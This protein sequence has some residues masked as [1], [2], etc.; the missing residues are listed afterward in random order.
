MESVTTCDT[1]CDARP[2]PGAGTSRVTRAKRAGGILLA[3]LG[4]TAMAVQ[5]RVNAQLGKEIHDSALAAVVSF[6]G[7][8]LIL[9]A[10]FAVSPRMRTGLGRVGSALRERRLRPWHL[11]GGLVGA[12]YVLGQSVS[13]MVLGVAMFT[14]GVVAGQ[15]VSGLVVDKAG[16]GPAGRRPL[17]WPRVA[18]ALLT[19]LAVGVALSADVG[20]ADPTAIWL[21][22]LPLVAGAGM[23]VQQAF[24]G[25]IGAV[26]GS[27]LTAAL[28]NFTAGT[29]ALVVA[30]LAS[31]GWHGLPTGF[32]D[33]PALYLGGPIG[34]LFIA[35]AAFVVSWIGVLLLAL[36]SVA[37]Q[38][39]GSVLL[40]ALV[41]AAAAPLATAT[42]AGCGLALVAVV[43]A[44][45]GGRRGERRALEQSAA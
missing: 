2:A 1:E 18:G 6:G 3:V 17:T 42:L 4:G 38:L 9:L 8:L 30:W 41:P 5:S 40:D 32:P 14:V 7:G 21:L 34:I 12:L 33:N 31:L 44:A 29:T 39:V 43:V 15:T 16:L 35:T 27:P 10:A 45:A 26:S 13:V 23:S 11:L 20:G 36:G 19:V 37:G 22:V 24:N 25:H 28:V